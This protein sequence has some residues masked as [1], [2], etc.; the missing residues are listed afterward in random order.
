MVGA[1]VTGPTRRSSRT[2]FLALALGAVAALSACS[3][4]PDTAATGGG[5]DISLRDVDGTVDLV[6]DQ[7]AARGEAAPRAALRQQVAALMVSS[8][9]IGQFARDR[10]L[11]L[12]RG[13]V[14]TGSRGLGPAD[15]L[16]QIERL[17]SLYPDV[18]SRAAAQDLAKAG[19]P[20]NLSDPTQQQAAVQL[21]Q[22]AFGR[23]LGRRSVHFDPRLRLDGTTLRVATGESIAPLEFG[24]ADL[25]SV[26]ISAVGRQEGTQS[27]AGLPANQICGARATG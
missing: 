17:S 6:C 13:S 10:G 24:T 11:D 8:D 16:E 23:W 22:E 14:A 25:G 21:G 2:A 27:L 26:P 19:S 5:V 4:H 18:L 9:L 20:V 7:A 15:R 12:P 1:L 3:A